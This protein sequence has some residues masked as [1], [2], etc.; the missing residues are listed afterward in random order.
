[1]WAYTKEASPRTLTQLF[2]GLIRVY[3][4][5]TGNLEGNISLLKDK[6]KGQVAGLELG[7]MFVFCGSSALR[8]HIANIAVLA[9]QHSRMEVASGTQEEEK[10]DRSGHP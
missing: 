2:R 7:H 3:S 1:M 10:T 4:N 9:H 8:T 6:V 5:H